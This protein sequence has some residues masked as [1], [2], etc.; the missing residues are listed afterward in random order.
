MTTHP[1]PSTVIETETCSRCGGTG[2]YSYNQMDGD[3]CY[4]CG[5]KG[6]RLTARGTAANAYLTALRSKPANQLVP[7]DIVRWENPMS[8]R[9]WWGAV[10]TSLPGVEGTYYVDGVKTAMARW[11]VTT[12]GLSSSTSPDTL[13]R[14]KQTPDQAEKTFKLALLF[15]DSLTKEGKPRKVKS[16]AHETTK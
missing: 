1:T 9:R 2:R 4:G 16:A 6:F 7:G 3:R 5:G 15:Q 14:V 13:Y 11:T 12:E 10:I 8:G